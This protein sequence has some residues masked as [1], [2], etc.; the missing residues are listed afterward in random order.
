MPVDYDEL[1]ASPSVSET[2]GQDKAGIRDQ[3]NL[4]VKDSFD[5]F[6]DRCVS[7]FDSYGLPFADLL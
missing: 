7:V 6:V 3:R 1:V 4:T 2:N 5:L